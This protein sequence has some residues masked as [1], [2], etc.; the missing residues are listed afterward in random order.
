MR[1]GSV[2]CGGSTSS[3]FSINCPSSAFFRGLAETVAERD[4]CCRA[5]SLTRHCSA[6]KRLQSVLGAEECA[7][8]RSSGLWPVT[9]H[10]GLDHLPPEALDPRRI[11]TPVHGSGRAT[12]SSGFGVFEAPGSWRRHTAVHH[13]C[14][15]FDAPTRI[16]A[17]RHDPHKLSIL[18]AGYCPPGV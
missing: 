2:Q 6:A 1:V 7:R 3:N 13:V 18:K 14:A 4:Q 8:S 10:R 15:M 9:S 17:P 16:C 5:A 12:V 11:C